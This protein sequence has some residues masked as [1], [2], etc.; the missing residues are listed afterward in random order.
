M[1]SARAGLA[2]EIRS[3]G[4]FEGSQPAAI[5]WMWC[6]CSSGDHERPPRSPV[7]RRCCRWVPAVRQLPGLSRVPGAKPSFRFT[8][9]QK[10][11]RRQ[12]RRR[13]ESQGYKEQEGS[14]ATQPD[15][16][17]SRGH[18]PQANAAGHDDGGTGPAIGSLNPRSCS[19]RPRRYASSSA[20]PWGPESP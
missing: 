3:F 14:L 19:A 5:N 8:A 15:R 2:K 17:I 20:Q 18:V 6:E 7:A 1:T 9:F 10:I 11:P 16:H 13:G 12:P 4:G